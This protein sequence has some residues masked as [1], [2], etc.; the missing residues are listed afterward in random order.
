MA[1]HVRVL[2]VDD[3]ALMRKMFA[4]ILASDDAIEVVGSA[5]DPFV[6]RDLIKT[7]NPDV[8]TLDI[9]MPHMDGIAFLKKIMELRPT[10]VV[11]ISNYTQ[12]G[13]EITL[14]ALEISAIDFVGK[15]ADAAAMGA[16]ADELV[17]KFK[18][19]AR[20]AASRR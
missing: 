1:D 10:P 15:P 7:L 6:A 13:A 16:L 9:E 17:P 20:S 4:N 11:M 18:A 12:R 8:V 5:P 3:S 2:I 14:E 19:A